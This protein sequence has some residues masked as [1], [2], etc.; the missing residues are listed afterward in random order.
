MNEDFLKNDGW[1]DYDKFYSEM[2]KK[3]FKTYVELGTWKGYSISFLAKSILNSEK[4]D[5]KIYGVDLFEDSAIHL[6]YGNEHLT[7]LV[8]EIYRI[9]NE[10]LTQ[11]G[12]RDIIEDIKGYS[13]EVAEKF[14]DDSVDFIFI[15][16]DHSY[17]SVKKDIKAWWPKIKKGGVMSGHDYF[18]FSGVRQAVD[19]TFPNVKI[20]SD[21]IWYIEKE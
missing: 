1:F 15:D 8:P 18:S 5:F 11:H 7:P 10:V 21:R 14:E 4:K 3:D 12:V 17:E 16:A 19:E 9:Y 2:S 20:S 6:R 13:W